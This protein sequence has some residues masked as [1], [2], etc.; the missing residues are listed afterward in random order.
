M[1][2]IRLFFRRILTGVLGRHTRIL[3]IC[4]L[5]EVTSLRLAMEPLSKVCKIVAG[6]R[7]LRKLNQRQ[8]TALLKVT[9]QCPRKRDHDW[10]SKC[11]WLGSFC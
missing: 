7:Y 10:Q 9:C 8:I 6:Q 11:L 4:V 1:P 5:M 3:V 2:F